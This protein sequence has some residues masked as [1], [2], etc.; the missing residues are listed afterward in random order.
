MLWIAVL[1]VLPAIL[2]KWVH[3]LCPSLVPPA[4]YL[5]CNM[6]FITFIL[7]N[8]LRFI[9]KAPRVNA[10][11][12][13]AGIAVYLMIGLLWVFAY[14]RIGDLSPDA[15]AFNTDPH[16]LRTMTRFNAFYFSFSTLN[17]NG[18]GDITPVSKAAR[19]LAVVEAMTGM[20]YVAILISRLVSM[21]APMA[22][23]ESDTES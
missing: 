21:Y 12:V 17:L 15:F 2:F 16:D 18:Y 10:E 4:V 8:M 5:C 7:A 6:L 3:H 11:V 23:V 19:T 9:M 13:S 20:F 1:L 22:A 14:L